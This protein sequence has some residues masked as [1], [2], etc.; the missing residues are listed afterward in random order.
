MENSKPEKFDFREYLIDQSCAV[1]HLFEL[2][3]FPLKNENVE[4]EVRMQCQ[5]RVHY[6]LSKPT[7]RL[8]LHLYRMQVRSAKFVTEKGEVTP[9][10][11]YDE[12]NERVNFTFDHPLPSEAEGVLELELEAVIL[13]SF[14]QS[15]RGASGKQKSFLSIHFFS[16]FVEGLLW[17]SYLDTKGNKRTNFYTQCEP[18]NARQLFAW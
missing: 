16:D 18:C 13:S 2:T 15:N 9:S 3:L 8:E 12:P 7:N 10:V 1:P 14:R 17:S 6:K 5:E 4:D 11:G